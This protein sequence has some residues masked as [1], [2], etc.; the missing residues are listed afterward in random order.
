MGVSLDLG[1]EKLLEGRLGKGHSSLVRK[2]GIPYEPFETIPELLNKVVPHKSAE[3]QYQL[4][5]IA[6]EMGHEVI[7]LPLPVQSSPV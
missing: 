3:K 1:G 7:R 5:R 2:K 4:D 6:N